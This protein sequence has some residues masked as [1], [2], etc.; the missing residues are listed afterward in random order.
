MNDFP[1]AVTPLL[2]KFWDERA[3]DLTD[4]GGTL[5]DIA[6]PLDSLSAVEVVAELSP[7][8]KF[9]IPAHKVIRRGGYDSKEQFVTEVTAALSKLAEEHSS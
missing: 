6:A 9:K 1:Q 8:V 3:I 2:E 7:H 4:D 5:D